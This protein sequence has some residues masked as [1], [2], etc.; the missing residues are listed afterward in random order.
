MGDPWNRQPSF[1]TIAAGA[2]S[3]HPMFEWIED[4][5]GLVWTAGAA[6]VAV[7]FGSLWIIPALV[8]RIPLDY[9]THRTRPPNLWANQHPFVRLAMLVS[10]NLLGGALM[11]AGLAMLLLPGQGLLT[12]LVGFFLVDFP[13]KYRFEKWLV[14]RRSIL[15]PINWLRN[16]RGR[17]PLQVI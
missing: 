3:L 4:H 10:K 15:R 9:F 14:A 7:C 1:L 5:Q 16:R 8:V 17:M 2:V 12:L 6:S 13:G 11:L